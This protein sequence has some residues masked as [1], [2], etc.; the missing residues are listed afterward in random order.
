V[1]V[2][3]VNIFSVELDEPLDVAGFRH[4]STSV[5]DRLGAYRIGASIYQGYAG[6]PIWPYGYHHGVEEW[7]YV[8]SGRPVLREPA[9]ERTLAPGDLVCFPSGHLGA[10]ALA[11]PGRFVIFST[12]DHVEPWLSVYPDSDKVSGPDGI[13]LRSSAVGYWHGEGTGAPVD[14]PIVLTREPQSAA[15]QPLVNV[16]SVPVEDRRPDA[17]EGFRA[18]TA[19]LGSLLQAERLGATVAELDPGVGSAPYHYEYGREEW[20][21][22]LTGTPTL[23]HPAG[24]E[25]LAAGEMVCFPRG[26]RRRSLPIQPQRARR[27]ARAHL[28]PGA[29]G[30]RPLP[31]QR[32]VVAPQRAG[33]GAGHS[34]RRASGR[35]YS[36]GG[37]IPAAALPRKSGR[38]AAHAPP[39]RKAAARR[40]RPSARGTARDRGSYRGG[41]VGDGPRGPVG[42]Q[43]PHSSRPEKPGAGAA[44]ASTT[45][46]ARQQATCGR[47]AFRDE[48]AQPEALVNRLQRTRL[49]RT[50]RAALRERTMSYVRASVDASTAPAGARHVSQ[51]SRVPLVFLDLLSR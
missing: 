51:R 16:L 26:S 15:R 46:R 17:P 1:S 13:L 9:G 32:H 49:R 44:A 27:T 48:M 42:R 7:L 31:R 29:A 10:H 18:R 47:P 3:K 4:V 36:R 37:L 41:L 6:Q 2:R 12:G 8:I 28:N 35:L 19:R 5:R 23:R 25:V 11:G 34:L 14:D 22:V 40:A 24:K 45:M 33:R 20:V 30:Q 39:W 50:A 43:G 21:L 38:L